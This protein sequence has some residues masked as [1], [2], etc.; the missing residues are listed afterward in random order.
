V[1]LFTILWIKQYRSPT[2][3]L[4]AIDCIE[5]HLRMAEKLG[6]DTTI[7]FGEKD[8]L[9]RLEDFVPGG[10]DVCIDAVEFPVSQKA[11]FT[12]CDAH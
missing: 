12:T 9:E 7:N 3:K 6:A 5:E 11:C 8:F 2:C 1:A 4:I 10:P